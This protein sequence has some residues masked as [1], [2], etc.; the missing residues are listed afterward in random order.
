MSG[1]NKLKAALSRRCLRI[2]PS[3]SY[4]LQTSEGLCDGRYNDTRQNKGIDDKTADMFF[5]CGPSV[6]V[7]W[8]YLP[9]SHSDLYLTEVH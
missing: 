6:A 2:K 8:R 7:C 5:G 1:D 3:R 4:T 9:A